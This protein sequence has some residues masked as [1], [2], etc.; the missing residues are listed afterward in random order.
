MIYLMLLFMGNNCLLAQNDSLPYHTLKNYTV[1]ADYQP[2]NQASLKKLDNLELMRN[3]LQMSE[4]LV[5][6]SGVNIKDYGGLA[7]LKTVSVRGLGANHTAVS[8]DGVAL[9]DCQTGQ[10]DVGKLSLENVGE[11]AILN[12]NSEQDIFK[13]ARLF[14]S[15]N[16]LQ[17]K[18]KRPFF[19]EGK[20]INLATNVKIA[21]ALTFNPCLLL[22]NK[23]G[24]RIST[25]ISMEYLYSKGNYPFILQYGGLNDSIS[26]EIRQNA[27]VSALST[28]ANFI[29]K[30]TSNELIIKGYLYFSN[31]GLPGAVILYSQNSRQRL[32][33]DN[34]FLQA[35]YTHYFPKSFSYR[36]IL[37]T[38]YAHTH[39]LDPDYLNSYGKLDNRYYQREYYMSNILLYQSKL[40]MNFS[41]SNDLIY[42]NMSSNMIGFCYP[43]R[44]TVL[45][46]VALTYYNRWVSVQTNLL[47]TFAQNQTQTETTKTYFNKLS[48]AFNVEF[49]LMK[50]E[51]LTLGT[52]YQYVFR[53]PTF[54]DMYYTAVGNRTLRPE[55]IN[56][57]STNLSWVKFWNKK[58]PFSKMSVAAYYHFV[59]DKIVAMPSR[60]LFEWTMLNYGK[61]NIWGVDANVMMQ[62]NA[63]KWL[64]INMSFAYVYQRAID[65]TDKTSK[66]YRQQIP[67]TPKHSGNARLA[68]QTEWITFSYA[69]LAVG[70]RY[71]LRNNVPENLLAPY[72]D[73]S[74]GLNRDFEIKSYILR[75]SIEL[76]NLANKNYEVVANYPVQGFAWRINIGFKW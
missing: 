68:L 16:T 23:I 46:N 62:I 15:A 9:T 35:H 32:W 41:V 27:D 48:P 56:Q 4:A 39:Y 1:I 22:E 50:K 25:S 19:K 74:I 69:L 24:N 60:S 8:F 38:N 71:K 3:A 36:F 66:T 52:T 53:M 30:D 65:V 70:S 6:F 59:N 58:L 21:S 72:F 47:H 42:N 73:H 5:F 49:R 20:K 63:T 12:A 2:F 44:L 76:L 18:T 51:K 13:P 28:V 7:G 61:V 34:I 26:K 45:T 67:Y 40:K 31:K 55:T 33:E 64:N 14:A 75:A 17:I 29:Y 10:I 11:L 37:K 43:T 54:N 57:L